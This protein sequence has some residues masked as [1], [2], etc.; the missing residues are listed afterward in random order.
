MSHNPLSK[1]K[2]ACLFL[3][4]SFTGIA[5]HAQTVKRVQPIWWF[6]ESVAANYNT[7]RGT[8]Q[9]LNNNTN[10]PT[11]FHNGNAIKPY[12]SLLTEY[13]PNKVWGGMLN[14]AFDNRGGSFNDEMAPCN[15]PATLTTN[16]SYIAVE[17][18]VRLAPFSSTFYVFA[19]PTLG[20]NLS[21]TFEYTQEK[22]QD[23]TADWSAIR[24]TVLSA[25]AGAGIDIPLSAR[26]SPVQMTLS[27][28]ASFQTDLGQ[29]PRKVENWSIYTVR[30]GIALKF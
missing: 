6:G 1:Q 30:A 13:R 22:Q 3:M 5:V 7:Y 28:F 26:T 21:K 25:Q 4:L 8:T 19:G 10:V 9:L 29:A 14:I 17:P 16:L 23:K 15:C 20:I 2:V 18:S 27:P 12:A 24:K 11:A